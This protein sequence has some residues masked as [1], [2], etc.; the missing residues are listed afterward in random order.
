MLPITLQEAKDFM[1]RT[2]DDEDDL[3]S[4]NIVA[5]DS[6][7]ASAV[8]KEY[9]RKIQGLN[10]LRKSL[11]PTLRTTELF[12]RIQRGLQITLVGS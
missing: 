3:I 11:S 2:D 6:Y 1:K 12:H 9:D 10:M 5:A 4:A 7:I 8:G